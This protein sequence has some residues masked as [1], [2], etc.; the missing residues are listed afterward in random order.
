MIF[1]R[2]ACLLLSFLNSTLCGAG[3]EVVNYRDFGAKGDGK[4]DDLAAL[5]K[6]HRYANENGLPV[7]ADDDATY[8]IGG[9]AKTIPI[10]TDTD[11]GSAAFIIDDTH[12]ENHRANVFELH[13]SLQ[14]VELKGVNSLHKGQARIDADLPGPSL[15]LVTNSKV[16]RFIRRG[17]NQNKGRAQSDVFLVDEHG[18]VDPR[19]PIIWDF[20]H[21]SEIKVYPVDGNTLRVKGGKFTTIAASGKDSRYHKRGI[22]VL[23]SNVILEGLEHR[24]EGEGPDGPPYSGFIQ[25]SKAA[26]VEQRDCILS[27]HKTYY[28]I[29]SAG[30]RVP[31]GSY[32]I[33]INRSVNVAL[34]RCTQFNDIQDRSIWGIMGTNFCK[35]LLLDGCELSRF[36]AH[37]GVTNA[38]IRHSTLGYMGINL[39]GFGTALIENTTVRSRD[40]I[41]LRRDYG[42]TWNGE[43]FIRDCRFEPTGQRSS[44]S[45]IDGRNDGQHDFGYTTYLPRRVVIDGLFIDDSDMGGGYRGPTIFGNI[46]PRMKDDSYQ[47]PYPQVLPEAVAYRD[48]ATKSGKPLRFSENEFMFRN[49]EVIE[50]LEGK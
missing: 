28:K 7:R 4:T 32:D 12:L 2:S 42:S 47:P 33:T 37:M 1:F 3:S 11:F 38:T 15:V 31:M 49:V 45:I 8:Y 39:I 16:M 36:D 35:N 46:N 40:F 5:V 25:I 10:M 6:A 34:I 44:I 29:G 30:K 43:I 24:I 26:D 23:R 50:G 48:V 18:K 17:R 13:S 20:D 21:I 19:T 41:S 27:G 14:P 22:G 9:A